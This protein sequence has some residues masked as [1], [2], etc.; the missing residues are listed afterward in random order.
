LQP[1]QRLQLPRRTTPVICTAT[2]ASGNSN[3]CSFTVTVI[4]MGL[5]QPPIARCTNLTVNLV[6]GCQTNITAEQVNNGSSDPENDPIT[7]SISPAGPLQ[8]RRDVGDTDRGRRS[9]RHQ[10]L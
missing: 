3:L 4:Q 9:R 6:A 2:D 7:L 5:N 1:R 8:P 10:Q